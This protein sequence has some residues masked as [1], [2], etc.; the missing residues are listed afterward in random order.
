[1]Q[2]V[3]IEFPE[4]IAFGAQSDPMW[5]T[6]LVSTI[7]GSEYTNQNWQD[8]RHV[9]DVSLAIRTATEYAT[10]RSHF[11][12]V[13][14]RAKSFPFK[15]FLDCQV[16]SSQGVVDDA[17][18]ASEGYQLFKRY[19]SGADLYDR[20]ITRPV[21]GTL[22]IYRTRSATTTNVTADCTIDYEGGTFTVT[23]HVGGD[24]YTWAGEFR[25]PVRYD[26][27]RLPSAVTNKQPAPDGELFVS[28]A[29]ITLVEVRE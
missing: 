17:E 14:G 24:V 25:V 7:G 26:S 27:D 29:G 6:N 21:S 1:M 2:Y 13:R 5:S 4:R 8:C 11:H 16:T 3:D 20:K 28:C 22:T 19:G 12:Q 15:D 18:D 23:G 9:Y 10:V